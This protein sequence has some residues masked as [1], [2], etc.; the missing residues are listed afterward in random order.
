MMYRNVDHVEGND[1]P[2]RVTFPDALDTCGAGPCVIMGILNRKEKIGYLVH[3]NPL[4]RS[5]LESL[6]NQ[7]LTEAENSKDLTVAVAGNIPLTK[8]LLEEETGDSY[9]HYIHAY[10]EHAQWIIG[11]LL[12]NGIVKRN[13]TNKLVNEPSNHSY[14]MLV[15]TCAMKITIEFEPDEKDL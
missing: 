9:L 1:D 14:G 10:Q 3:A 12:S 13:I 6:A 8:N 4:Q 15:D 5:G 11:F 2:Q 7:A